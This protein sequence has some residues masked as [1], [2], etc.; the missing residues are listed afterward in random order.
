[1][2]VFMHETDGTGRLDGYE[3]TL[4]RAV[5]F[6]GHTVRANVE[7]KQL[8]SAGRVPGR[9]A[10]RLR[11][12]LCVMASLDRAAPV[13]SARGGAAQGACVSFPVR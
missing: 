8:R 1:M 11:P 6:I 5:P 4:T 2:D 3:P 9:E 13:I 10:L 12:S 7:G